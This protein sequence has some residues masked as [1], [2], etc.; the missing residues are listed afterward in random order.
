VPASF[1]LPLA[2][3]LAGVFL[4]ALTGGWLALGR[5]YDFVGVFALA[6]V[7]GVG[8]AMLRDGLF[9]QVGTPA[10]LEDPRYLYAVVAASI[11]AALTYREGGYFERSFVAADALGLGAYTAVGMAKS[12]AH[13][14][15]PIPAMLVGI[16]NAVGGGMLRDVLTAQEPLIF[17][18][19][20]FYALAALAGAL[21]FCALQ[22]WWR[23]PVDETALGTIGVTFALRMLA[24]VLNWHTTPLGH[25]SLAGRGGWFRRARRRAETAADREPPSGSR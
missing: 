6:L 11:T 17:K 20:Q 19:G 24:V 22:L 1:Q 16:S 15:G 3:D 5:G 8:G 9:L 4:F 14:L 25:W 12:F 18:P 21:T 10:V 13:G 23:L 2:F 7:S